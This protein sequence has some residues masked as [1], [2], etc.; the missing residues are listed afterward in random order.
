MYKAKFSFID[1]SQKP[2][3]RC[4]NCIHINAGRCDGPNFLAMSLE[5][6][7][8]WCRDR[9]EALDWTN[10]ELADKAG[11]AKVTI[12]RIMAGKVDDLKVST[13]QLLTKALV[14]GSWGEHPCANPDAE[15]HE[16]DWQSLQ[17]A[18]E[19]KEKELEQLRE[20]LRTVRSETAEEVRTI[21]EESQRKI[22]YL[23]ADVE[24][25]DKIID[26]LLER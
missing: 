5:R 10:A 22:D 19:E 14:N 26:R 2:Y 21:R 16:A 4:L 17:N 12:D 20:R 9:K 23:K 1:L 7:C 6:F 13:M 15:Y 3:N 25:K 18:L 8:E 11:L 24:K